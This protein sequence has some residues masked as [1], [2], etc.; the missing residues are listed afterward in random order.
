MYF[1]IDPAYMSGAVLDALSLPACLIFMNTLEVI[2]A[3][4]LEIRKTMI[5]EV[6]QLA[7]HH[8]A[9]KWQS[10]NSKLGLLP[11]V[12]LL[13]ILIHGLPKELGTIQFRKKKTTYTNIP[14][15]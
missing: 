1:E 11:Q 6:R 9:E 12:S 2:I 5:R 14:I 10:Q 8:T 4:I 3:P 7:R 13:S 15:F